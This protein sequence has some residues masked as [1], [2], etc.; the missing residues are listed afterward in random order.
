VAGARR[1]SKLNITVD[2]IVACKPGA[3]RGGAVDGGRRAEIGRA[4]TER[5]CE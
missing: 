1:R 4:E 3:R 5:G 2:D